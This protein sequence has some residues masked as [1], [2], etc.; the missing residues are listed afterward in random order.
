MFGFNGKQDKGLFAVLKQLVA[1]SEEGNFD[2]KVDHGHL[3]KKESDAVRLLN[4]ALSNYKSAKEYDLM[5]YQLTSNA[6][7]VAL[8]DMDIVD[9]DPVNPNNRI[10]WSDDFRK[11]FGFS[12]E[13][14]F[15]NVLSSWSDRIHPDD[16]KRTTE[17]FAAHMLP[18]QVLLECSHYIEA[19]MDDRSECPSP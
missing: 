9:G 12:S 5:K 6:L 19:L 7:G 15:P 18:A 13:K 2:I 17:A 11:M 14:D 16:Q 10:I 3:S 8:W 4:I 1:A